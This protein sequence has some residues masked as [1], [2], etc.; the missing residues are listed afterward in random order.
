MGDKQQELIDSIAKTDVKAVSIVE[1][2]N[3]FI[4]AVGKHQFSVSNLYYVAQMKDPNEAYMLLFAMAGYSLGDT[5]T[6][7]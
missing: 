4:V 6:G 5:S 3:G 2:S 1:I 7:F